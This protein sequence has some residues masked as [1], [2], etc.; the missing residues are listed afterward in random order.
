MRTQVTLYIIC[1]LIND[2]PTHVTTAYCHMS[3][4]VQY[5]ESYKK[6]IRFNLVHSWY[7]ALHA[8]LQIA[9]ALV[10]G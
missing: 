10:E 7:K 8:D 9:S 3:G 2:T 1:A 5:I 6:C 4:C